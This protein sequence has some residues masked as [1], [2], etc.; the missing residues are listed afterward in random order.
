[1]TLKFV[2]REDGAD[3]EISMAIF[4]G[5]ANAERSLMAQI[6]FALGTAALMLIYL[7]W[8]TVMKFRRVKAEKLEWKLLNK[9]AEIADKKGV[10][11]KGMGYNA[12]KE[13]LQGKGQ[14]INENHI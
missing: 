12:N 5:H 1:M 14:A 2:E 3:Q 13:F 9:G 10:K 6:S 4:I 8:F 7:G 11:L